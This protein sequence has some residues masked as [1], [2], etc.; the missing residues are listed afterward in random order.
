MNVSDLLLKSEEE[1]RKSRNPDEE[2]KIETE[3]ESIE[4]LGKRDSVV[5]FAAETSVQTNSQNIKKKLKKRLLKKMSKN[6]EKSA[7]S[8]S[9]ISFFIDN[10]EISHSSLIF[11]ALYK[12]EQEK[13]NNYDSNPNVWSQTYIITYK[14][15]STRKRQSSS[16]NSSLS[17]DESIHGF[18]APFR[19]Y[20]TISLRS[21]DDTVSVLRLLGI[22]NELNSRHAEILDWLHE[23]VSDANHGLE[24][25]SRLFINNKITAKMKRQLDEPLIVASRVLPHWCNSICYDFPFLLPFDTRVT[26]LQSQSFGYSRNMARW[27]LMASSTTLSPSSSSSI[28]GRIQRQK[29][30]ISRKKILESMIKAM[31]SYGST[32]ALLEVEFFDEVGTGLGPTLEFYSQVCLEI[33]RRSGI[34]LSKSATH[35]H[36][37]RDD[38]SYRRESDDDYLNILFPYPYNSKKKKRYSY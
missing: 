1:S 13:T 11:E 15:T 16:L 12:Y 20:K 10:H 30:R 32:Q 8:Q 21:D 18:S 6:A 14:K 36:L 38:S 23:T 3:S 34:L 37:W 33:R 4:N 31:D 27:Q 22:L 29:I 5:E 24:A 35:D 25:P 17:S 28:L 2:T 9:S 26:Y 7:K 19:S